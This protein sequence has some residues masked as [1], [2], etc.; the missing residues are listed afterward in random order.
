MRSTNIREYLTKN[1]I[2]FISQYGITISK[3]VNQS[4][5][6]FIDFYLPDYN[7]FIEYNGEQH[8]KDTKYFTNYNF[9]RQQKRDSFIQ[10]YCKCNNIMLLILN[11][12]LKE[13]NIIQNLADKL[14]VEASQEYEAKKE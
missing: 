8:Y 1:G 11:Y 3:D 6:A 14:A 5:N 4:G 9:E 13:S 10:E 7:M 12:S 2:K